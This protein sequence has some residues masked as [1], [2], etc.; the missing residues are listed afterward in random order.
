MEDSKPILNRNQL[1]GTLLLPR[2]QTKMLLWLNWMPFQ[3]QSFS[4]FS[5]CGKLD[6]FLVLVFLCVFCLRFSS[7]CLPSGATLKCQKC[8]YS[9]MQNLFS[10]LFSCRSWRRRSSYFNQKRSFLQREFDFAALPKLQVNWYQLLKASTRCQVKKNNI[11]DVGSTADLVL[12]LLVYL[13]H[14][15][16]CTHWYLILTDST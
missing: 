6:A 15:Y 9:E 7:L 10:D 13:V 16:T 11:R 1:Y 8:E 14:W 12:I 2:V 3:C 4:V 5:V